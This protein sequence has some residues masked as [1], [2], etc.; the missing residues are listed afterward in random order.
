M[1]LK[2]RNDAKVVGKEF[3]EN[4]EQHPIKSDPNPINMV[5]TN[6]PISNTRMFSSY[7]ENISTTRAS[8][9]S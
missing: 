7:S 4:V 3:S 9:S 2:S 6:R 1:G 5:K 8:H